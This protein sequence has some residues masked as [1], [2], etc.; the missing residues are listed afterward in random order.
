M[1]FAEVLQQSS[2]VGS[3]KVGM[4][5]GNETY[6]RYMTGFGFGAPTGLGL[7]GES[8]GLLREP[9]RWSALSLPTMSIGQEIS[10]TAVQLVAAFGAVANGGVLM[11]PRLMR[12]TLDADGR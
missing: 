11:Q 10:V 3:I 4:R 2:N 5:L 8:R 1:T 7:A 12:A 9:N 6:H